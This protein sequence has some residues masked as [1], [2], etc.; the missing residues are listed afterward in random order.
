[1][2][3]VSALSNILLHLLH[4][5]IAPAQL[6][7]EVLDLMVK[8]KATDRASRLRLQTWHQGQGYKQDIKATGRASKSSLLTGHQS[9]G[10]IEGIK[11]KATDRASKSRLLTGHQSQG[12][13]Q[14]KSRLLTR[15]QVEDRGT[16]MP[17]TGKTKRIYSLL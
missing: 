9:Q 3:V 11:V 16:C 5:V 17:W 14:D 15:R 2:G 10:Y 4:V 8:V 13:I 12:Y 6:G 1:M 7:L